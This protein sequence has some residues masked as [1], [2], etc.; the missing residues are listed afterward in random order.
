MESPGWWLKVA[1]KICQWEIGQW[2]TLTGSHRLTHDVQAYIM[3]R[4]E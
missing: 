2:F 1:D 3:G 4:G